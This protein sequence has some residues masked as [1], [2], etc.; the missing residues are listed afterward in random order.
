MRIQLAQ[1]RSHIRG[2]SRL[3]LFVGSKTLVSAKLQNSREEKP[4]V[5][6]TVGRV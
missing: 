1:Q 2:A 6:A 4:A 3:T 5:Q